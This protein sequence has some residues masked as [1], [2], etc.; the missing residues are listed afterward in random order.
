MN[1]ESRCKGGINQFI[2]EE[3]SELKNG[4]A[5]A[6]P[7][8]TTQEQCRKICRDDKGMLPFHCKSFH[9]SQNAK[10]CLL[11]ER[12]GGQNQDTVNSTE[13]SF[14]Q[15]VCIQGGSLEPNTVLD[16]MAISQSFSDETQEPFVLLRQSLLEAEPYAVYQG[17]DL[18]RCLDNCLYRDGAKKCLSANFNS[19][20]GECRLSHFDDRVARMVY[21]PDYNYYRNMDESSVSTTR[22]GNARSRDYYQNYEGAYQPYKSSSSVRN[23]FNFPMTSAVSS[24]QASTSSNF[25]DNK[26]YSREPSS[27][28]SPTRF[29]SKCSES[30]GNAFKQVRSRTRL[31]ADLIQKAVVVASIYEC[32]NLCLQETRFQ[33]LS[34][35]YMTKFQA[36]LPANCELSTFKESNF[37]LTNPNVFENSEDFDFYVRESRQSFDPCIDGNIGFFENF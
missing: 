35:N 8:G 33:C 29:A 5:M 18:G 20:S 13:F 6:M 11:S 32:E 10:L 22:F 19:V 16:T 1:G 3:S 9:Y 4:D 30:I 21:H 28:A 12:Q 34:F 7:I 14:H 31:R 23:G 36:S 2:R 17:Y 26:I 25:D 24:Q 15:S 37:D 27:N